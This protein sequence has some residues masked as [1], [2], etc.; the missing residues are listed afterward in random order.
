[1][2]QRTLSSKEELRIFYRSKAAQLAREPQV[3]QGKLSK[4][5]ARL[6]GVLPSGVVIGGYKAL[7]DEPDLKD[8]FLQSPHQIVYPKVQGKQIVFYLPR[9]VSAFELNKYKIW[10]PVPDHSEKMSSDQIS[11]VVV[12]ALAFD[13][14]GYRLGRGK[15]FYDRFLANFNGLKIG[16]AYT[17]QVAS[18][19]FPHDDHDVA[20]DLV[21]TEDYVLQRFDS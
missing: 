6:S 7:P 14:R 2:D 20:M 17:D 21:V 18:G 15:G 3:L 1:L 19:D 11:A 12:P 16:V 5:I 9:D 10:E 8:V 13:R 4:L